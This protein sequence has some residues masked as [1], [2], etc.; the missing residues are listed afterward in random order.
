M[1]KV[2]EQPQHNALNSSHTVS[3]PLVKLF[4]ELLLS[5]SKV[6]SL[7]ITI[8]HQFQLI[9]AH[10]KALDVWIATTSHPYLFHCEFA[11]DPLVQIAKSII[12][13][14]ITKSRALI[15][16]ISLFSCYF[17]FLFFCEFARIS[18]FKV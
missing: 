15:L 12:T 2:G 3:K 7:V 10:R 9:L 11:F 14:D 5:P 17:F 4:P 8:F 16:L 6:Q 1:Q 18:C 13:R